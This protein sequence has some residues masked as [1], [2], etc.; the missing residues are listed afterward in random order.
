M[1][2]SRTI[3]SGLE[4]VLKDNFFQFFSLTTT[5]NLFYNKLYEAQF[6]E[7]NQAITIP[8]QSNFSWNVKSIANILLPA[9]LSAQITGGY[10]AP[11]FISQGK[12]LG[13]Y[14]VDLG[15]RQGSLMHK[16]LI[17]NL[18]VRDI[19]NSH[20]DKVETWGPNFTQESLNYFNGRMISL[21]VSYNFGNT[22]PKKGKKPPTTDTNNTNNTDNMTD[23]M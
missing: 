11:Y 3:A 16:K 12:D 8:E 7:Y 20:R 22:N 2:G 17:L 19:F 5:L 1:N 9:N 18:N 14:E 13:S 21:N 15:L 6:M 23:G 4:T 10:T